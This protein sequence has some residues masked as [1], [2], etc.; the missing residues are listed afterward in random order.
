MTTNQQQK[1]QQPT[2]TPISIIGPAASG[3]TPE[4][5]RFGLDL[6]IALIGNGCRIICGGHGGMMEAVC[7]G[8]RTA[9]GTFFGATTGILPGSG[10]EEANPYVDIVIPTGLGHAR[11][12][13]V[14][15]AGKAVIAIGGG[16]GTLSEIALAWCY[17]RPLIAVTGLGG[18]SEKL[19][20]MQLDH[21]QETGIC[22]VASVEEVLQ[23]IF[24][25]KKAREI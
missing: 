6:G 18:W 19:A 4:Q 13:I 3:C 22:K 2:P 20:G 7:K 24:R 25:L 12:S 10:H 23:E 14:A 9:P 1:Q 16:A 21:R 8:A 17:A 5:Y 11:N 15:M